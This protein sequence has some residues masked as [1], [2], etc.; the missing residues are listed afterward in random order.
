MIF[1]WPYH[2]KPLFL[3]KKNK[4][5][6]SREPFG[7]NTRKPGNGRTFIFHCAM[8]R[9]GIEKREGGQD[10]FGFGWQIRGHFH[11]QLDERKMIFI[12]YFDRNIISFC[13]SPTWVDDS[14]LHFEICA[15]DITFRKQ[16]ISPRFSTK[17]FW[18]LDHLSSPDYNPGDVY[19]LTSLTYAPI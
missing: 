17:Q 5:H 14:P 3:I 15:F 7:S 11:E 1:S 12:M 16:I 2:L 4:S 8:R 6:I 13:T 19:K 10:S 9:C 18:F